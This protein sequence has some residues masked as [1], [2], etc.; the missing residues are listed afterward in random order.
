MAKI[1]RRFI[2][3]EEVILKAFTNLLNKWDYSDITIGDLVDEADINKSTFYLHYTSIDQVLNTLQDRL[4]SD[5]F[6][7]Y[8]TSDG[9]LE[10]F[11]SKLLEVAKKN[12]K[13]YRTVIYN[14]DQHFYENAYSLFWGITPKSNQKNKHIDSVYY[15]R[16]SLLHALSNS[17][18]LWC[19]DSCAASKDELQ[20]LLISQIS[21]FLD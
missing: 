13:V 20:D 12:R 16:F 14:S 5:V 6:E 7:F 19:Q 11:I 9:A 10:T 3:S 21:F 1:D 17:V 8:Q 15:K 4:L 18:L 2:R